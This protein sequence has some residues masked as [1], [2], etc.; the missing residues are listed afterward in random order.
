MI[1][2]GI[3]CRSGVGMEEVIAAIEAVLA[4]DG[5][6]S[7]DLLALATDEKRGAEEGIIAAGN[8][9]VL[10]VMKLDIDALRAAAARTVTRS[11]RVEALT[12]LP[13][14][15]ECAAL[16]AAGPASRLLGPRIAV[17]SVT[18]AIAVGEDRA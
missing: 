13:S 5:V 4:R 15:A 10:P 1:I 16:A 6:E 17:G 11:E 8:R 9:L 14:L 7:V 12:G 3:G 2:A 18:C